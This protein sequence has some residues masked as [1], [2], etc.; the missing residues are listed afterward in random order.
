MTWAQSHD[1]PL[2]QKQF[3]SCEKRITVNN[4]YTCRYRDLWKKNIICFCRY[5]TGVIILYDIRDG[6]VIHRLRGHDDEIH[7]IVWCPIPG[8]DFK[9]AKQYRDL[10]KPEEDIGIMSNKCF[11]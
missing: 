6:S 10:D 5:K 3:K 9:P 7:S 11:I 1:L 2:H 4:I 8:E